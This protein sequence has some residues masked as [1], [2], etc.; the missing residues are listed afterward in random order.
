MF[1][2]LGS[3]QIAKQTATADTVIT[4][5]IPPRRNCKTRIT[6]ILYQCA[7]TAHTITLL[8]ALGSS[9]L[10]ADVAASGTSIT[11]AAAPVT[12]DAASGVL[13]NSDWVAIELDNG[14]Y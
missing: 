12:S 13:A 3:H 2:A 4:A 10:T 9:T 5:L 7:G 14:N 1:K 11:L 6:S 8:K